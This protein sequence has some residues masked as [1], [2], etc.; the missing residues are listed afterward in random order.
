MKLSLTFY[1]KAQGLICITYLPT[2][3]ST[4]FTKY[5]HKPFTYIDSFNSH[6]RTRRC[7]YFASHFPD[8]NY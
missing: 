3:V 7:K 1:P 8:K 6:C 4:Y 2:Y 5:C